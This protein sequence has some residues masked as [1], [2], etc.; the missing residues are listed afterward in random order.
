MRF[1][2]AGDLAVSVELG[3]EISVDVNTRVRALEF[4]IQ[5]KGLTGVV[6]TVPT[7]SS[8]LVYYDPRAIAY[9][10]L[11]ASIA[12]LVPQATTGVLPPAR[13]V[14]LPCCYD[15]ELG[16][17]LEAAAGRLALPVDELVRLHASAEYLVYFIGFTPGL[18]YMTGMPER[19]NI[20]RLDTPRTKTPPGSV[21]IGGIQCCIYS[22]ESPG[23]FWILGRTPLRLYDADAAEPT[24]LRPGDRVRFR[25]IA[26]AEFDAIAA[27][28]A[29]G[30]W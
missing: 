15:A 6:E 1:L 18:P 17:D 24:L 28:V 16:F 13:T 20:P 29:A 25:P 11:C 4:L 5:Q 22:V 9:E 26:R 30:P 10:P 23:G 7:F 2:P 12:E 21:G 14:E 19:I 27:A 3:Q 8:L